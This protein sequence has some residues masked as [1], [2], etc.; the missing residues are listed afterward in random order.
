MLENIVRHIELGETPLQAAIKGIAR[1]I[2][3]TIIS[4][5]VS[6]TAVF[7]PVLFMSGIVG[8]LLHEFA[9]T[10]CAAILVSGLVSLTLTPMLCSR[11]LRHSP[12]RS[13]HGRDSSAPSSTF[14]RRCC[15]LRGK[16]CAWSPWRTAHWSSS[17]SS[18]T[19]VLS[20]MLVLSL[21]YPRD[22]LPSGDSGQITA[23]PKARRTPPS[24][25]GRDISAPLRRSSRKDPNIRSFMSSVGAGGSRPTSNTGS[26]NLI[27]KPRSER[28]LSADEIIQHCAPSSPPSRASRFTC[29]TRRRSAL[30]VR[31]T[32]AQYQ[33][34]LQSTD[35]TELYQWTD[36]LL[37]REFASCPASSTSPATSTTRA[38]SSRSTSTA[39]RSPLRADLRP[40]RGRA[41]KRLQRVRF[42]RSTARPA[43]IK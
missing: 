7:I 15:R 24:R 14:S 41:A 39:T 28:E 40:G 30:A 25:H 16:P 32:A 2:G 36:I 12:S 3:F 11:Y 33:Y 42:R 34:T 35:L 38:R 10:I 19:V 6:L 29:R 21:W 8:R 1:E 37:D 5:T 9:V 23:S 26:L 17:A 27:L 31:S 22:F 43:S 13:E 4:M 20:G 18:L